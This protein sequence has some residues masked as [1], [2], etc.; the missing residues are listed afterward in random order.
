MYTKQLVYYQIS[1]QTN[2]CRSVLC[3]VELKTADGQ[4]TSA[5]WQSPQTTNCGVSVRI[6][7]GRG[8]RQDQ[9]VQFAAERQQFLNAVIFNVA[10]RI[11]TTKSYVCK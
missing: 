8:M 9:K 11:V 7:P 6:A 1:L 10:G 2:T 4:Y 5:S 3:L